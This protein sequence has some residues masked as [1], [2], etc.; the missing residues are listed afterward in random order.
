MT[1]FTADP[2]EASPQQ[3]AGRQVIRADDVPAGNANGYYSVATFPD[4]APRR[5]KAAAMP[6]RGKGVQHDLRTQ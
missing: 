5:L 6:S 2:H 1:A 4:G 3:W